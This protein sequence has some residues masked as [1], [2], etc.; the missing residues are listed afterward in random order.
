[1]K[2]F[3]LNNQEE[4]SV[5]LKIHDA[6]NSLGEVSH[7]KAAFGHEV[8]DIATNNI[9]YDTYENIDEKHAQYRAMNSLN[10]DNADISILTKSLEKMKEDYEN[11]CAEL[12]KTCHELNNSID[13]VQ[14]LNKEIS[15]LKSYADDN[16]F[17]IM[18][19]KAEIYDLICNDKE[20]I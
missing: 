1:M 2:H 9:V 8:F 16:T 3:T 18:R 17:E 11:V 10:T 4:L 20:D 19:L 13:T 15:D 12:E 6:I 14:K 7:V 5:L